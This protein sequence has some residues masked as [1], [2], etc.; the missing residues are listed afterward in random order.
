MEFSVG[1]N[2][3]LILLYKWLYTT[4]PWSH[5]LLECSTITWPCHM[6]WLRKF[7]CYL[8]LFFIVWLD[9]CDQV[10]E[11]VGNFLLLGALITCSAWVPFCAL[12]YFIMITKQRDNKESETKKTSEFPNIVRLHWWNGAPP[13]HWVTVP[14][15]FS[16]TPGILPHMM[17]RSQVSCQAVD[18]DG[19]LESSCSQ[20]RYLY[21]A[22]LLPLFSASLFF[23]LFQTPVSVHCHYDVTPWWLDSLNPAIISHQWW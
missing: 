19:N 17:A 3:L 11:H 12:E 2:Y 6:I 23:L 14:Y 22:F 9:I 1:L 13:K 8:Y 5:V 20:A 18:R 15:S 4:S 16:P 21:L 7:P 10:F